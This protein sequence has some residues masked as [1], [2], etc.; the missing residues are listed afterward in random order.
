MTDNIAV[1]MTAANEDEA[2]NIAKTLV[3]ERLCAC[4][5]IVPKIRSIYRWEGKICD[6]Q[7]VMLIAKSTSSLAPA[8]VE[9]V[10]ALHS[11]DTPEVICLPVASGSND[12]LGWINQSV[13]PETSA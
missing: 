10:K 2:T 13:K 3:E 12:Y 9:R 6:D 5:N 4:V 1:F 11:Y 8:I 7:E